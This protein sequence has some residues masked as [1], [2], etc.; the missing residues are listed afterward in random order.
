VGVSRSRPASPTWS[1]AGSRFAADLLPIVTGKPAA[2]TT[3]ALRRGIEAQLVMADPDNPAMFG[4][5]H[6]L[7]RDALLAQVSP[8]ERLEISRRALTALEVHDPALSGSACEAA[9]SLA[10][11]I[12]D[13]PN[14]ARFLL[15]AARRAHPAGGVPRRGRARRYADGETGSQLVDCGSE[16]G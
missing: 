4:F 9:V 16:R 7:T 3:E 6:A 12:G 11:A 1:R 5:R 10:E 15:L 2:T 14:S 13:G 8:F